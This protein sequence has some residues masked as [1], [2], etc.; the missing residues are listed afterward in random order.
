MPGAAFAVT[1]LPKGTVCIFPATPLCWTLMAG[2]SQE[3][4]MGT[5]F[6]SGKNVMR[7][8]KVVDAEQF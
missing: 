5:I 6:F 1:Q 8:S 4:E 2:G 7:V 3:S